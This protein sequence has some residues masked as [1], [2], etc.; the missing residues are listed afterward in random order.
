MDSLGLNSLPGTTDQRLSRI[1]N[2]Q[3]VS[4]TRTG[5]NT[6]VF[7]RIENI[8]SGRPGRRHD[9]PASRRPRGTA[10]YDVLYNGDVI[11]AYQFRGFTQADGVADNTMATS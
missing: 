6:N 9:R 7:F 3:G 11:Q 10:D 2:N 5:A 1:V 8:P 4:Y